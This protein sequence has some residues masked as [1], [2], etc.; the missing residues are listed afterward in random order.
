MAVSV[1]SGGPVILRKVCHGLGHRTRRLLWRDALH[2]RD[3][4]CHDVLTL[5]WK[6]SVIKDPSGVENRSSD[7]AGLDLGF[8]VEKAEARRT[9]GVSSIC[10]SRGSCRLKSRAMA[11]IVAQDMQLQGGAGDGFLLAS[12]Q[13][14]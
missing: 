13:L 8:C 11:V 14:A 1:V 6:M 4:D 2:R 12:W 7:D 3:V 5:H 9:D 10:G